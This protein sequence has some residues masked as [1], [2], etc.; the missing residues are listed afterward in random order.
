MADHE[1]PVRVNRKLGDDGLDE[2]TQVTRVVDAAAVEI[3]AC[4]GG[5]PEPDALG[6]HRAVRV[7]V[8]EAELVGPG[9]DSH[10]AFMDLAVDAGFVPM[11][12]HQ[13]RRRLGRVVA[14]RHVHGDRPATEVDVD[15]GMH[16]P[17]RPQSNNQAGETRTNGEIPTFR[18][19]HVQHGDLPFASNIGHRTLEVLMEMSRSSYGRAND[20]GQLEGRRRGAHGQQP[21]PEA[22][23]TSPPEP[24]ARALRRN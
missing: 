11:Q 1:D 23:L 5:V 2:V 16:G 17:R 12:E 8:Q 21:D 13:Q 4:V 6:V 15:I 3:A 14:R 20:F 10:V 7:Q 18:R 19:V 22:A 24:T 9:Q